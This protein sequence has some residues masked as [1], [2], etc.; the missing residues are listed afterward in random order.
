MIRTNSKQPTAAERFVERYGVT[1]PFFV[2]H[3]LL[4]SLLAVTRVSC[5]YR[6]VVVE[7]RE[8]PA[9]KTRLR[10][11]RTVFAMAD[12]KDVAEKQIKIP[13]GVLGPAQ[14]AT[15]TDGFRDT[16]YDQIST[17]FLVGECLKPAFDA[18]LTI[19]RFYRGRIV[20]SLQTGDFWTQLQAGI[21]ALKIYKDYP[22]EHDNIHFASY[23]DIAL[24]VSDARRKTRAIKLGGRQI[25]L[26]Y[27]R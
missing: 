17:D 25:Q 14:L 9:W 23:R 21:I 1:P 24:L 5:F 26:V 27:M 11:L 22:S 13:R 8:V 15:I 12:A 16:D 3:C 6:G 2:R 18:A 10:A 4:P 19:L 20:D 7:T